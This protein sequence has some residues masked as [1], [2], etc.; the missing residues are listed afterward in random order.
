M[1]SIVLSKI[2]KYIDLMSNY[3]NAYKYKKT[4]FFSNI[5]NNLQNIMNAI[6]RYYT[7]RNNIT[8]QFIMILLHKL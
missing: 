4:L 7:H 1:S 5:S 2:K 8:R 3:H 6:K